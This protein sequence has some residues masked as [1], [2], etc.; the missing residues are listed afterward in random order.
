MQVG[1]S[2]VDI[3]LINT[4]MTQPG[5]KLNGKDEVH[6][7]IHPLEFLRRELGSCKR[8]YHDRSECARC[9]VAP[10]IEAANLAKEFNAIL[11]NKTQLQ[12]TR[13]W[14]NSELEE[15]LL[16]DITRLQ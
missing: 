11:G 9:I 5:R 14:L 15:A 7:P 2:L 6:I 16:K 8:L 13:K 10:Y 4:L 12:A 1:S 3:I